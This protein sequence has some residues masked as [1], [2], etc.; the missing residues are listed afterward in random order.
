MVNPFYQHQVLNNPK[1]MKEVVDSPPNNT[2]EHVCAKCGSYC[3]WWVTCWRCR[4]LDCRAEYPHN[5]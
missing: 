1:Y 2:V 3:K 4:N 5:G